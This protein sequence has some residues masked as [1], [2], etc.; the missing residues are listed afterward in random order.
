MTL[1]VYQYIVV[2]TCRFARAHVSE[3]QQFQSF[4]RIHHNFRNARFIKRINAYFARVVAAEVVS[5]EEPTSK[6]RENLPANRNLKNA[7]FL[8][9]IRRSR[10]VELSRH[11]IVSSRSCVYV[12]DFACINRADLKIKVAS[13]YGINYNTNIVKTGGMVDYTR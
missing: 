7:V 12:S 13:I 4:R 10:N 6:D 1:G 3:F 5:K 8:I 9:H 11:I 2:R